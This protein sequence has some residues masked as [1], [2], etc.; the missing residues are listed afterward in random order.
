MTT[1]HTYPPPSPQKTHKH[2]HIYIY[3]FT[4]RTQHTHI[5]HP[6][7]NTHTYTHYLN[8]QAIRQR[9]QASGVPDLRYLSQEEAQALEPAVYC[10][11]VTIDSFVK[12]LM[13]M[14]FICIHIYRLHDHKV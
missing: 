3:V 12:L 5:F 4:P 9:A 13:Y 6:G 11:K 1:V 8:K 7:P 14:L 2:T 10:S